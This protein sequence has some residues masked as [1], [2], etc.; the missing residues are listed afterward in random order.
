MAN[1][2]VSLNLIQ[3]FLAH[4]RVAMVGVS[5]SE[6]DFSVMLYKELCRREYDVVP[7]NPNATEILG[8]QCFAHIKDIQPAVAWALLMTPPE[9]TDPVV[10]ECAEAGV[11]RIWLYHAGT[12]GTGS[13]SAV[14][15]C[16]T[17][18]IE[19]V[20]GAC[21]FMFWPNNGLHKVHGWVEKIIGTFPKANKAA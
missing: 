19:V 8:K 10:R 16:R 13:E 20:P 14:E 2:G 5:R 9:V 6:K 12:G 7:V 1:T 3:D 11:R 18:G 15:F 4:K 21:P 17:N